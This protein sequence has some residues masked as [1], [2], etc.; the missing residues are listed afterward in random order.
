MRK[1]IALGICLSFVGTAEAQS[2]AQCTTRAFATLR[3]VAAAKKAS[4]DRATTSLANR[5]KILAAY[6]TR[7]A[8][9]T[10]T[11]KKANLAIAKK[12]AARPRKY[13]AKN[14]TTLCANA[15]AA[16]AKEEARKTYCQTHFPT[17]AAEGNCPGGYTRTEARSGVEAVCI[18]RVTDP[19]GTV[20]ER[21]FDNS[22]LFSLRRN[23]FR[24]TAKVKILYAGKATGQPYQ[25]NAI[26]VTSNDAACL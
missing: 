11:K 2:T 5:D 9:E 26:R 3:T 10:D 15:T 16:L 20:E 8:A 1:L 7:I 21:Y 17:T 12:N 18:G 4:C 25:I 19:C 13:L 6:D 22:S 23:Q 14:Q 24:R